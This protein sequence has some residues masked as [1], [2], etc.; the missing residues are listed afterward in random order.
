MKKLFEAFASELESGVAEMITNGLHF[1]YEDCYSLNINLT[2]AK[3]LN[4]NYTVTITTEY[5]HDDWRTVV[6]QD[7]TLDEAIELA[8]SHLERW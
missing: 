3:L 7:I 1:N 6:H 8:K 4:G 5:P 2:I